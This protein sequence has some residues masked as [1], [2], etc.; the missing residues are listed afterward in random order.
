MQR[1][2]AFKFELMPNGEPRRQIRRFAES[3]RFVYNKTLRASAQEP[4]E[5]IVCVS[6]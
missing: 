5:A 3:V 6:I 2:Q 1:R 4:A